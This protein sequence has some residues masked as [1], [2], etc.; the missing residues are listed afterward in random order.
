MQKFFLHF[1]SVFVRV[2]VV[3]VKRP[4]SIDSSLK[5]L[6]RT[7]LEWEGKYSGGVDGEVKKQKENRT[8]WKKVGDCIWRRIFTLMNT[9]NPKQTQFINFCVGPVPSY[10]NVLALGSEQV[11][12]FR[13]ADFSDTMKANERMLLDLMRAPDESRVVFLTASGTGAMDAAVMN[14]L[15]PSDSALVIN[16]GSF[17][18]RFSQI[19]DYHHI[20]YT[21]II[22]E[23][24]C[25]VTQD[26]LAPYEGKGY[27]AFLVNMDETSTGVLYDVQMIGDFC[28]RN[29][30]FLLVDAVSAFLADPLVMDDW[31]IGA[32]V[33]ASQ[34]A[35]ALPPGLSFA[36]LGPEALERVSHNKCMCLYFDFA[37]YLK[38]GERGQTPFTPAVQTLRQLH[39]R[40]LDLE[41]EGGADMSV[42][43][44]AE[45]ARYFRERA[46]CGR[47]PFTMFSRSPANGVTSIHVSSKINAHDIFELLCREYHI[48]I[49]PNGGNLADSVFRVGHIG[50]LTT[51]DYDKLFEAFDDLKKRGLLQ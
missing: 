9:N 33:T 22:P 30:I 10:E 29:H 3:G 24:G 44:C 28:R 35:L 46:F 27:S 26:M 38:D 45:L 48:W 6:H 4:E 11:P 14:L 51:A 13:T 2:A 42:A 40:L 21:D 34:K 1:L 39:V 31:N 19:C 17:G 20:P 32:V 12:Y 43:H 47:Y 25:G 16:G 5:I 50:A 8:G 49:C 23:M 15:S 7:F 41:R 36:V 18:A 37:L